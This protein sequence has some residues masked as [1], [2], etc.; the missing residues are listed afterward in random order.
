MKHDDAKK[1]VLEVFKKNPKYNNDI[2]MHHAFS[3]D[4]KKDAM[5]FLY[6]LHSQIEMDN[7]ITAGAPYYNPAYKC[8]AIDGT[9]WHNGYALVQFIIM[10]K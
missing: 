8:N 2:V 7:Q 6:L 3:I 5:G 4:E 1:H 10:Y 9:A